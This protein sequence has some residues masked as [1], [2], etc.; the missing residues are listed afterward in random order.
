MAKA[1]VK[2]FRVTHPQGALIVIAEKEVHAIAHIAKKT[3]KAEKLSATDAVSA[4]AGGLK[5]EYANPA[6]IE[7]E[8]LPLDNE[9]PQKAK[10]ED[11]AEQV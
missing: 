4:M 3:I 8:E 7:Q 9:K 5:V 11:A 10:S 6:P 1:T 2:P